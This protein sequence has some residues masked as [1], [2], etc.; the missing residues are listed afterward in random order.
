MPTEKLSAVTA[1]TNLLTT[2][3]NA[4]ADG[5]YSGLG[6]E[7]DNNSNGD[8]FAMADLTV[9][10]VSAP[11]DRAQIELYC[12]PS[13]DG[14]NYPDVTEPSSAHWVASFTVDNTT[15]AQRL[16]TA[17]FELPP[18]KCKFLVRNRSGQ[19]FPATGSIVNVYTFNR[20]L[21]G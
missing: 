14:T 20:T 8:R 9:D 21:T 4:L 18:C 12:V 1:R 19:A 15:A 11:T 13:L 6:V 3:L 2:H 7:L 16:A 10:F 5:S 17:R